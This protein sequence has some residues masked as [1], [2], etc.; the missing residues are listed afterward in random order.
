MSKSQRR[1]NNSDAEKMTLV[2]AIDER[3]NILIG[4]FAGGSGGVLEKHAAWEEVRRDVQAT[5]AV[6]RGTD[7]LKKKWNDLK[8]SAKKDVARFRRESMGTGGGPAPTPASELHMKVIDVIGEEAVD[9]VKG[10][11]DTLDAPLTRLAE[12]TQSSSLPP[13]KRIRSDRSH[14]QMEEMPATQQALLGT[15]NQLL[16]EQ[17]RAARA[18]ERIAGVLETFVSVNVGRPTYTQ[19]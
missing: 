12:H 19:M 16:S 14:H 11:L 15:L 6:E 8:M 4:S 1:L 2:R 10:G 7:E 18:L 17:T 9:G 13:K 3:K 5:T